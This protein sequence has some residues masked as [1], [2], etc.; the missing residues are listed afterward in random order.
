MEQIC[1]HLHN[2]NLY[3]FKL[4]LQNCSVIIIQDYWW[5]RLSFR[6]YSVYRH[7]A[8]PSRHDL[9]YD[10][11]TWLRIRTNRINNESAFIFH[12]KIVQTFL[13]WSTPT[14]L[15]SHVVFDDRKTKAPLKSTG[16][17]LCP[18]PKGQSGPGIRPSDARVVTKNRIWN[19]FYQIPVLF[20][21]SNKQRCRLFSY[22]SQYLIIRITV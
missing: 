4:L 16:R 15:F 12:R 14:V 17:R 11:V 7:T 5:S 6:V 1:K 20:Y 8:T 2:F 10:L 18:G 3:I 21:V 13:P 22:E 9:S 19:G